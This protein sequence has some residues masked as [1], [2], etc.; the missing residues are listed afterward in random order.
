MLLAVVGHGH[1]AWQ[2][3]GEHALADAP[4]EGIERQPG[5]LSLLLS[6]RGEA[7][8]PVTKDPNPWKSGS[9]HNERN[10]SFPHPDSAVMATSGLFTPPSTPYSL[11]G[12]VGISGTQRHPLRAVG[13]GAADE[14]DRHRQGLHV[15]D[16]AALP[17]VHGA[18]D[19]VADGQPLQRESVVRG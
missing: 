12:S 6:N 5:V 8:H 2:P 1:P 19:A 17:G 9:L 4:D 14:G 11:I 3:G 16:A 18:R 15:H 10:P 13:G 7:P